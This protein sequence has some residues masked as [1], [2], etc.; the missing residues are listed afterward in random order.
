[1][2]VVTLLFLTQNPFLT[3]SPDLTVLPKPTETHCA[4]LNDELCAE[5]SKDT[6]T[7]VTNIWGALQLTWTFMLLFVHLTQVARNITTFETMRISTPAGPI[8]TAL[9]TGSISADGAQIGPNGGGPLPPGQ[10]SHAR[11]HAKKSGGCLSQWS[12][13]LGIDTF[14]TIA[15]QGYNRHKSTKTEQHRAKRSNPFSR[16]II[17]NC[18]DFWSDGSVFGR[19]E[20]SCRA[21]LGGQEVNY[22][23]LYDVPRTTMAY[24]GD[25]ESVATNDD[26]EV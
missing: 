2:Y 4:I 17:R 6:F 14:L 15:F 10:H 22:A 8:T 5:F 16:G 1:M 26:G 23:S 7:V 25:Y 21:K 13:I 24:R 19:K 11:R 12:R 18:I 9:A 20:V 3:R